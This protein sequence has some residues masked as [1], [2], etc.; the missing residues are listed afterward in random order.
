MEIRWSLL[1][2]E[3]ISFLRGEVSSTVDCR[4][5]YVTLNSVNLG[6]EYKVFLCFFQFDYSRM[7]DFAEHM[8]L[9]PHEH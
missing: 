5:T 6:H 1:V 2:W 3:G 8:V 9:Y 4:R 7:T